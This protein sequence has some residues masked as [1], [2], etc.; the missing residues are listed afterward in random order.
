MA[1]SIV[2]CR[3]PIAIAD[4]RLFTAGYCRFCVVASNGESAI[5]DRQSAIKKPPNYQAARDLLRSLRN[6][7]YQQIAAAVFLKKLKHL[8]QNPSTYL[9]RSASSVQGPVAAANHWSRS[10]PAVA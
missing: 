5:G 2:D 10:R 8:Q 3:L 7:N 9:I 4:F 1:L 6:V